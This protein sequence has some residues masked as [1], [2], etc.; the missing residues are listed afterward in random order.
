MARMHQ[1]VA[2]TATIV[3][4]S[5]KLT[6][7]EALIVSS[8]HQVR[9]I[10]NQKVR[11]L[12]SNSWILKYAAILLEKDDLILTTDNCLNPAGF[13]MG[14]QDQP[15]LEHDWLNIIDYQDKVRSDL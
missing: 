11:W 7:R 1:S 8:P 4:E 14:G 15:Q 10:L 5:R 2:A 13:L 9:N 12:L 3:E 6:F